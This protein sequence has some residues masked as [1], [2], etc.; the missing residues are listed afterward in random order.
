MY[1][2]KALHSSKLSFLYFPANKY[3]DCIPLSTLTAPASQPRPPPI[4]NSE[5]DAQEPFI[6]FHFAGGVSQRSSVNGRR[7]IPP[8]TPPMTLPGGDYGDY[9]TLCNEAECSAQH[10]S[11]T[12]FIEIKTGKVVQIKLYNIV[13]AI[14]GK[15]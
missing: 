9:M 1:I 5:S 14:D 6:N 2:I 15:M 12:H 11:C 8:S 4:P 13:T 3:A 10:C 7:F